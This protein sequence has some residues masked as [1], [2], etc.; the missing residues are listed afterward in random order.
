MESCVQLK[1]MCDGNASYGQVEEA[2]TYNHFE[3]NVTFMN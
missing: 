1:V 3:R 2:P